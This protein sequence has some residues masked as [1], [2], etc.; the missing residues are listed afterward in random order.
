MS[1][2]VQAMVVSEAYERHANWA[3]AVYNNVIIGG[4]KSY[5][6]EMQLHIHLTSTLIEDVVTK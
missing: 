4:E 5:L 1:H 3:E 2:A 6:Q